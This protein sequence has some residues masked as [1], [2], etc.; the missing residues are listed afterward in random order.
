MFS[1]LSSDDKYPAQTGQ[2][3]QTFNITECPEEAESLSVI[4]G[5]DFRLNVEIFILLTRGL[6]K[7]RIHNNFFHLIEFMAH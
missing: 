1:V 6:N 5:I 7:Y 3:D 4:V 2:T